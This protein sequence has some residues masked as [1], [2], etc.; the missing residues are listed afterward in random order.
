M[1]QDKSKGV[2]IQLQLGPDKARPFPGAT[3]GVYFLE[4]AK[5]AV[6]PS[7]VDQYLHEWDGRY[8]DDVDNFL[9]PPDPS[10]EENG[11][12]WEP[13]GPSPYDLGFE[14]VVIDS[15]KEIAGVA[16]HSEGMQLPS[17]EPIDHPISDNRWLH[18]LTNRSDDFDVASS[19]GYFEL[20]LRDDAHGQAYSLYYMIPKDYNFEDSHKKEHHKDPY[21]EDHPYFDE[22][23]EPENDRTLYSGSQSTDNRSQGVDNAESSSRQTANRDKNEDKVTLDDLL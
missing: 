12:E 23:Y 8:R 1:T 14:L 9:Y 13:A 15:D 19:A 17:Q 11:F 7:G 4:H 18:P 3:L 16:I 20:P 10:P 5:P 22:V 6:L 2:P 21:Y